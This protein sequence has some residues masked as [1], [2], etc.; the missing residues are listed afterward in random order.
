MFE[1]LNE[2]PIAEVQNEQVAKWKEEDL[3][4]K[5]VTEREGAPKYV[6]FEGP[7][8]ANGKPHIGHIETRVFNDVFPRFWTMK[9]YEVPRKAGWD[10]HGLPVELEVEKL[11]GINGKPQIE[12]IYFN[13]SHS[14]DMV[15]CAVSQ[16]EVGCD[17]EKIKE[18]KEK[19]AEH[20]FTKN[21]IAH[22]KLFDEK[23]RI[24]E[25][26]RIWTMKESYVK[27]TGEGLRVPFEAYE[28]VA[29]DGAQVIRDGETQGCHL[30]T[31]DLQGHIISICS[32][33]SASVEVI[34]EKL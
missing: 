15:V 32:E 19:I 27:M 33:S 22:L 9:G 13:L 24:D 2:R 20:F 16:K 21:E 25:F 31:M 29:E 8:T 17:L 4:H 18:V 1:K 23:E 26:F 11:L 14:H 10:T 6:F 5:C 7:P 30:C 34:W 28:V 3:L 12:G